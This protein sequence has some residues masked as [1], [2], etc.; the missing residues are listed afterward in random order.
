[1]AALIIILYTLAFLFLCYWINKKFIK[2][3]PNYTLTILFSLKIAY[4][5]FFLYVYTY[6]YG[7]GELT[8]DAGAFFKESIVLHNVFYESPYDF[9]Q[10][11]FG[12]NENPEFIDKYLSSTTHWN[13]GKTLLFNDSRNVIRTNA[14]LLFI[15]G[16]QVIV[17]F[18]IFSFASFIG[19]VDLFQWLKKKSNIPPPI[20]LSMLTLAPSLAFWSS[21]LIKEPLMILGL[22][23][24]IRG[25]FDTISIPRRTWRILVGFILTLG[26]K[27]YV[28]ICFVIVLIF[29][30]SFSK[31]FKRQWLT[32][33]TFSIFGIS[34][35]LSTGYSDKIAYIIANQQEDFIN[36]RDGGLYLQG[37]DEH[38]YYIYYA[39]RD[40]FKLENGNAVLLEPV[41]A[42]YLKK[43]E[44]F[45]RFPMKLE[46]VGRTY[47]IHLH[48]HETSSKVEVTPIRDNFWQMLLNIPESF[49]N[50]F[51]QPIPN[52]QSTWLQYPAFFENIL[53][54]ILAVLTFILFPRKLNQSDKRIVSTLLLF[55]AFIAMIVGWTTPV[56]GAIVRY[57]IPAYIAILAVLAIKLDY[58]KMMLIFSKKGRKKTKV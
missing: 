25:V 44:N 57:I 8:A 4:A 35:L 58:K 20:L 41:G 29:Y 16:G 18:I 51:F 45:E 52:K 46:E 6:H 5:L 54:A 28:L 37:D 14:L 53:F 36:L 40:H 33:L 3:V 39:N 7:G 50:S 27:P 13:G 10:F 21:S 12:L 55:A 49:I 26:F 23:L 15:T 32:L 38:Y 9:F 11:F 19:G 30:L 24:L 1:M 2:V 43:N 22:F 42:H 17:H 31:L 48:L 34:V 47:K 56:S